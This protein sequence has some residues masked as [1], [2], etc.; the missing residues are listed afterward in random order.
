MSRLDPT[1]VEHHVLRSAPDKRLHNYVGV[2][3]EVRGH[4]ALI[5]FN[6]KI[7]NLI[8]EAWVNLRDIGLCA[9]PDISRHNRAA[10]HGAGLP[11]ESRAS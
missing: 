8:S 3:K 7:G 5:V 4:E 11:K 2:I 9:K 10:N 1:A 6:V